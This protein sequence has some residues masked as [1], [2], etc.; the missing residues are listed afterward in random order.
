MYELLLSR[1]CPCGKGQCLG[2]AGVEGSDGAEPRGGVKGWG[3]YALVDFPRL[4]SFELEGTAEVLLRQALE[5]A[6]EIEL[7]TYD[8]YK[9][10]ATEAV[11]DAAQGALSELAQ[12]EKWHANWVLQAI[13]TMA[14]GMG[15]VAS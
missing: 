5:L 8:L 2:F 13:G 4:E 11:S 12:Q 14:K 9:K 7:G 10:L 15:R 3:G 1:W 6:L